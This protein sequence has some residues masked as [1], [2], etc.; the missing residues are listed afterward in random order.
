M[1]NEKSTATPLADKDLSEAQGGN[2]KYHD[3]AT[4][5]YYRWKG[6]DYNHKFLCP[7]CGRP[8]KSDWGFRYDCD[9]CNEWWVMEYSLKINPET[10]VEITKEQYESPGERY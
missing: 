3:E 10:W 9:H 6:S 8:V 2:Y 7:K 5:K 4:G 1:E